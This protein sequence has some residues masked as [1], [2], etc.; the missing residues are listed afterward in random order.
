M[1]IYSFS[2]SSS[3]FFNLVNFVGYFE[4]LFCCW[5]WHGWMYQW[6]P[7]IYTWT[8]R[9]A[10]CSPFFFSFGVYV[11]L[12]VFIYIC[13]L[14]SISSTKLNSFSRHFLGG[15]SRA[16]YHH[17]DSIGIVLWKLASLVCRWS[18]SF[19]LWVDNSW[20]GP[21]NRHFVADLLMRCDDIQKMM[22]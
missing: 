12:C 17:A 7:Y 20:T 22:M 10:T 21:N 9:S 14:L 1:S 3:S 16:L 15:L 19:L 11:R 6:P 5:I 8:H 2:L 18:S 13:C 4:G